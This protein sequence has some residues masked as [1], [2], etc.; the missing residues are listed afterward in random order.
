MYTGCTK[1]KIPWLKTRA[2]G[3]YEM[4]YLKGE[5]KHFTQI[6]LKKEF[7]SKKSISLNWRPGTFNSASTE[8]D[9]V[10]EVPFF[11]STNNSYSDISSFFE[12]SSNITSQVNRWIR[13]QNDFIFKN[14]PNYL[15]RNWKEYINFN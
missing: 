10:V 12:Y 2:S 8:I 11:S 14:T 4:Q 5:T 1:K 15:R 7:K 13:G 3:N 9:L 6:A